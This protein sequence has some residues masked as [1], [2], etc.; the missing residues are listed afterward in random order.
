MINIVQYWADNNGVRL[1]VLESDGDPE[2]GVSLVFIPGGLGAADDYLA[3]FETFAPRRCLSMSLRGQGKSDV[4]D[5]DYAF[6]D[7][8][9][10]IEAVMLSGGLDKPCLLGYSMGAPMA[11][12]YAARYPDAISGL[13]IG[14][15]PAHY[16]QLPPE[17]VDSA[18]FTLGRLADKPII[19]TIQADSEAL[20]LWDRLPQI[21]CPVLVLRGGLP[22]ARLDEANADKYRQ[23]LPQS[24]VITFPRSGHALWEPDYN[25]FITTVKTFL[26]GLDLRR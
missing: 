12:E 23:L 9:G 2:V 18:M 22:D 6:A 16:P 13:I 4:P 19:E 15:Y 20:D 11:I 14:D 24:Y 1:H 7:F 5:A 8:V 17:W 21:S 3:E 25:Q 26:R 10:D